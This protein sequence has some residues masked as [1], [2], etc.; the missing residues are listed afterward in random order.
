MYTMSDNEDIICARFSPTWTVATVFNR[1]GN[2][3][4]QGEGGGLV[5]LREGDRI[6]LPMHPVRA[7]ANV[8]KKLGYTV[9]CGYD[10]D[11][12]II[13][14]IQNVD[15]EYIY[16]CNDGRPGEEWI[17]KDRAAGKFHEIMMNHYAS[18]PL[19]GFRTYFD[20]EGWQVDIPTYLKRV[21]SRT[22]PRNACPPINPESIIDAI[23][24]GA[25]AVAEGRHRGEGLR[26]LFRQGWL[27]TDNQID[28][29]KKIHEKT[30]IS[31]I[32][33]TLPQDIVEAL[34][35]FTS[36]DITFRKEPEYEFYIPSISC[37]P[38][39]EQVAEDET[40]AGSS[41]AAVAAVSAVAAET[42][43]ANGSSSSEEDTD[44]DE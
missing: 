9:E 37:C 31:T 15:G 6:P 1:Y 22:T 43:V 29:T 25:R 5:H 44:D 16:G 18:R 7:V 36:N 20:W 12:F 40:S 4:M 28:I 19:I 33:N 23:E 14:N 24:T 32:G 27:V 26:K 30:G 39:S 17:K 21:R 13:M 34:H 38:A 35:D 2:N 8:I 11:W 3:G 42:A 10:A 41:V